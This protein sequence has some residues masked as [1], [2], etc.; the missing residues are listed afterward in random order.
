MKQLRKANTNKDRD[1]ENATYPH[2]RYIKK[3][4]CVI[5]DAVSTHAKSYCKTPF[6]IISCCR[7]TLHRMFSTKI[8]AV[9]ILRVQIV[10][11]F[12]GPASS[13]L[14]S[15]FESTWLQ[16]SFEKVVWNPRASSGLGSKKHL[17]PTP[18]TYAKSVCVIWCVVCH[19]TLKY[20][21]F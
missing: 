9:E 1:T 14:G 4:S 6:K 2:G 8:S 19:F 7:R 21:L 10:S 15:N 17:P 13:S 3:N 5:C 12:R 20:N 16:A 11:E 18:N